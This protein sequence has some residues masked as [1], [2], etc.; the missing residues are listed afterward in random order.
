[1]PTIHKAATPKASTLGILTQ[2]MPQDR[3]IMMQ[4][5]LTS[6]SQQH[7][8][9]CP[10]ILS[11]PKGQIRRLLDQTK[12]PPTWERFRFQGGRHVRP[13]FGED[14]GDYEEFMQRVPE[15]LQ[16][17]IDH[18][19]TAQVDAFVERSKEQAI[20]TVARYLGCA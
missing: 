2:P 16:Q 15:I 3:H 5:H 8:F 9:P 17:T 20:R 13:G 6:R 14:P 7:H 11:H 18:V 10:I 4:Y 19:S 12:H 1:M